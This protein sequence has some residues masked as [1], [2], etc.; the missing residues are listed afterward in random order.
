MLIAFLQALQVPLE[1]HLMH[2]RRPI[3]RR[4][5]CHAGSKFL[6][7]LLRLGRSALI[8]RFALR[9]IGETVHLPLSDGRRGAYGACGT[10]CRSLGIENTK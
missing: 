6:A 5:D 3:N 1:R 8:W 2:A 10:G 4:I 9:S 7:D